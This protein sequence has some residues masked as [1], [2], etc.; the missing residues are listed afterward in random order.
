MR[1]ISLHVEAAKADIV[2]IND[3]IIGAATIGIG[4][5]ATRLR[6]RDDLDHS[7]DGN[8]T[9]VPSRFRMAIRVGDLIIGGTINPRA[10][11]LA[12]QHVVGAAVVLEAK[13]DDGMPVELLSAVA[14]KKLLKRGEP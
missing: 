3:T 4:H 9:F 10:E 6:G 11:Y 5:F 2:G 13:A 12:V 8:N 7:D 1:L 14:D